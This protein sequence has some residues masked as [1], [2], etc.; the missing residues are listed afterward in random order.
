[1]KNELKCDEIRDFIRENMLTKALNS[2]YR[3]GGK[4][5]IGIIESMV[6]RLYLLNSPDDLVRYYKNIVRCGTPRLKYVSKY[7]CDR[8]II[9]LE[10]IEDEFNR[11]FNKKWLKK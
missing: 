3:K 4:K 5:A 11:K 9:R 7:L 2:A 6:K 8:K 10:D 1:M